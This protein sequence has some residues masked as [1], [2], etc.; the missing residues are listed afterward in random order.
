MPEATAADDLRSH[1]VEA[2][3]D[4]LTDSIPDD[5]FPVED[6]DEQTAATATETEV[7]TEAETEAV[8]ETEEVETE[9]ETEEEFQLTT[10]A[11]LAEALELSPEDVLTT[12]KHKVGES[13]LSLADIVS[14]YDGKARITEQQEAYRQFSAERT[15]QLEAHTRQATLVAGYIG[16]IRTG[17]TEALSSPEM[18]ALRSTDP[19]EWAA[20]TQEINNQV[21]GIDASLTQMAGEYDNF[22]TTQQREFFASEAKILGAEVEGWNE[23]MLGDAVETIKSL[24]FTEAEIVQIGDSRLVKAAL[25]LRSLRAE[26]AAN[27]EAAKVAKQVKKKVPKML[28]PGAKAAVRTGSGNVVKLKQK[29]AQRAKDQRAGKRVSGSDTQEAANLIEALLE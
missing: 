20:K 16:Q 23:G 4:A 11:D 12:L 17:L 25:E 18:A 29:F 19:A 6:E 9:T 1:T 10:V 2:A 7:E 24:G 28:Q 15:V 26:K 8:A 13:E 27:G 3:A 21:A 14:N 5:L 22:M